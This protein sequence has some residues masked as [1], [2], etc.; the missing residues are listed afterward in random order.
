MLLKGAG[1]QH[2]EMIHL[3]KMFELISPYAACTLKRENHRLFISLCD[4]VVSFLKIKNSSPKCGIEVHIWLYFL[5]HISIP[6]TEQQQE[7]GQSGSLSAYLYDE[8]T[9]RSPEDA[10]HYLRGLEGVGP[11]TAACVLML[12]LGLPVMPVDTRVT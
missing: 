11:K 4:G 3:H 1:G 5:K 9:R 10:W 2:S 7:A 6:L 8:L 12:N